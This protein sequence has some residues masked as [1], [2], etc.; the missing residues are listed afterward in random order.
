MFTVSVIDRDAG[1]VSERFGP[2]PTRAEADSEARRVRTRLLLGLV[3]PPGHFPSVRSAAESYEVRV[4][5][6]DDGPTLGD[7]A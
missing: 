6:M 7:A 3:P 1:W 5:E 2:Y 4:V